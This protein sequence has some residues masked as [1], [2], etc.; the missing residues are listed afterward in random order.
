MRPY[1][2][3]HAARRA[4]RLRPHGLLAVLFLAA[5]G[6]GSERTEGPNQPPSLAL[7]PEPI[8]GDEVAYNARFTWSGSDPDGFIARFEYA[9][10]PPPAFT[11]T[12]IAEGGPGI[13]TEIIPDESGA[14]GVTRV[15]KTADGET[16]SFTWIHTREFSRR[17]TFSATE[18][19][20]APGPDGPVSSGRFRG[21]HALYA[22]AVDDA[23][24]VS[25]PEKAAFT[26]TTV[27][28]VSRLVRPDGLTLV[29]VGREVSVRWAGEDPDGDFKASGHFLYKLIDVSSVAFA[30]RKPE[31][32]FTEP[33]PWV[34][35]DEVSKNL[36]A[37]FGYFMM[38]GVRAVD[39]AGA[40][41]PFLEFARNV[42][43]FN[44][45]GTTHPALTVRSTA[46][47]TTVLTATFDA[48]GN[49]VAE[50]SL[51]ADTE[52]RFSWS[53]SAEDYYGRILG[54]S[55]GFDIVDPDREGPES[56]WSSWSDITTTGPI[57]L[58]RAGLHTL[59]VRALDGSN[60]R[61]LGTIRIHVDDFRPDHDVLFVDDSY[62]NQ[63]PTDDQHDAFWASRFQGYG[64]AADV[65]SAHGPQDRTSLSPQVPSL[66]ELSRYRT[67]V[68]ESFGSGY[69][70]ESA[71][72]HAATLTP[73]LRSYLLSGGRLWV[74]GRMSVPPCVDSPNGFSAN[75]GY[76]INEDRLASGTFAYDFLKLRG[77]IGNPK[78]SSDQ[79][80]FL[81]G[82]AP[83]PEGPAPYGAMD[84]DQT[85]LRYPFQVAVPYVDALPESY[86]PEAE[87]GFRGDVDVLYAY[88]AYGPEREGKDSALHGRPVAI[89]W[90]DPDPAPQHGRIQ[91]FGFPLYYMKDSQAQE[92]FN[93][94]LDWFREEDNTTP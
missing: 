71:L 73:T 17:F 88:R 52:I 61:T 67:V 60:G 11:E 42:V 54:Y 64:I 66:G 62:D 38:L 30:D 80:D 9:L 1:P 58:S 90:H 45:Y 55:W 21:M 78:G 12:E 85:K 22:R 65:F 10:D 3:A 34:P 29:N 28:P 83:Y 27:A 91:W 59:Y 32:L 36:L 51:S 72:V 70:G 79:K 56:G 8:Q 89:R 46:Y 13:V 26:A 39:A 25:A 76:P 68:W 7:S 75:L 74:G 81:I 31:L 43:M 69:N 92:T 4:A 18:P 82:V 53:A 63:F 16:V 48:Q 2:A 87:P 50:L 20:L 40:E 94:S 49:P 24:A 37:G 44:V 6:C 15:S 93:R 77:P 33:G 14:G 19:D 86:D 41:E 5:W 23:G 57:T 47:G 84:V 35:A